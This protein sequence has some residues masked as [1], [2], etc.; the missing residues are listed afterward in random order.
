[1]ANS[2]KTGAPD[3]ASGGGADEEAPV[4]LIK[5]Y[6]NRKLYDTSESR[7]VTLDEIAEMVKGGEDV[8]IIDNRT[9]EDLTSI[10]L[11]QIIFEQEKKSSSMP[12]G[13]LRDIVQHGGESFHDFFE[14]EIQPRVV[15]IR[16][17]AEHTI[18]KMFRREKEAEPLSDSDPR[19]DAAPE[20]ENQSSATE[21]E[22]APGSAPEKE[23]A[24]MARML[25]E[26]KESIET[27]QRCLDHRLQSTMR[28]AAKLPVRA[29]NVPG[30]RKSL[31]TLRL[32]IDE[33]D[34]KLD[35]LEQR[36][37]KTPE[38]PKKE[39]RQKK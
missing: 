21:K 2:T 17:G 18:E 12:L 10:T 1:M 25:S 31:S 6:T 13:M 33:L 39:K 16:E 15:S 34:K 22:A 4:K 9:K 24:A 3:G 36:E 30:L 37:T 7:Y 35:D 28:D 11:A 19:D 32:R 5:R 27:W 8:R 23:S 20:G 29:M 38:Q 14:R 26:L